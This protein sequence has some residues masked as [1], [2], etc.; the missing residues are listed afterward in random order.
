MG[1][2][3]EGTAFDVAVVGA[4]A[5]GQMAA[6]AAAEQHRRVV[7][8]EQMERPG[9]KILASGGGRCNLTNLVEPAAFY[10]AFGR[11]GRFMTPAMAAMGSKALR[12]LLDRWGV[13]TAAS[14]GVHVFPLSQR[15]ADVQAAL[16]RRIEQLGVTL[17]C[18]CLVRGLWID[19]GRLMGV[20]LSA[21]EPV[22]ADRVVLACGGKSWPKLGGTGG[23]YALA[24]QAGLA[25]AEPLPALV[26][27]VTREGWPGGLAGVSLQ[28]ARL[29]I[30]LP[31]QERAGRTGDVLL[32]HRGLSG[33]AV[34]NLSSRVAELLRRGPVPL[35]IELL[36]GVDAGQWV[37][38]L[39]G[40]RG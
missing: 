38:R 13:P 20:E 10:A 1:P 37:R 7:L 22:A 9:L 5:A 27:L 17:R 8:W 12:R 3:T 33:P 24:R 28:H 39:E 6:I 21:R 34:L 18:H 14:D 40:W 30:D 16:R 19:A 4:G 25:I 35:R 36:A 15:S 26:P 23:G 29:W 11:Q 2:Q 31:G 32:T